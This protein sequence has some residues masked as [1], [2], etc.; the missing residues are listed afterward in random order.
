VLRLWRA[1]EPGLEVEIQEIATV[2]DDHP[3]EPLERSEGLGVFTS[4]L[5]R[6]LLEGAIDVAVHSYKDLPVAVTRGVTVAAV[7]RRG[8]A[9]DA[10]CA[11]GGRR[12]ADLPSGARVGTSSL[13]RRAQLARLRDDL[14][15]LPVRGNVPT[16]LERVAR[17]ELDAVV[18][19]R[20][21]LERLGMESRI[22][23]IFP[24]TQFL[25]APG[26]GALAIQVR[27][28]DRALRARLEGLEDPPTRRA[29]E[30]ERAL[31]HALHGGCSVPVGSL[32]TPSGAGL[33]LDA[34]VFSVCDDR[35]LRVQ[36]EGESW[37]AVAGD[38]ARRLL[39][40]GAADILAER[41]TP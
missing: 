40:M 19:A 35:A 26:Q 9:E 10:L 5:E 32:G 16:R 6:A 21:G 12:L 25:P 30:A 17:G 8:P 15:F 20:A 2:G 4:A 22:A 14:L 11:A 34:G 29:V 24:A 36:V 13:R 31:L 23:E 37:Q 41:V 38:A 39:V 7:P 28:E 3:D 1:L 33:V 18:L 27:S